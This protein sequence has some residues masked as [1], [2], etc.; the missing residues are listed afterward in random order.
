MQGRLISLVETGIP[1]EESEI[2]LQNNGV[3]SGRK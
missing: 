3:G 1:D 2:M